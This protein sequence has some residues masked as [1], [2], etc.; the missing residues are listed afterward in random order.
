M[1]HRHAKGMTLV[2]LL[3]AALVFTISMAALL[4]SILGTLYLKEVSRDGATAAFHLSNMMER[5]RA[6]SFN[7]L[8][9]QF[10]NGK[11]DGPAGNP[12][13]DIVGGYTL[14]NERITVRYTDSLADPRE[15]TARIQWSDSRNRPYALS[16]ST[17][18]TR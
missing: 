13:A 14:R 3:I 2:E 10:P 6:T 5:V 4:Q 9:A 17:A 12:Y 11:A 16:V 15:I 7:A 1:K 18:R 8:A